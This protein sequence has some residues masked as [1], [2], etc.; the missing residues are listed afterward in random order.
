MKI[1]V[2]GA[3]GLLGL[4]FC[5]MDWEAHTVTGVDRGTLQNV[6]FNLINAELT[7]PEALS[8]LINDAK[9]EAIIHAA[10]N[11]NVDACEDDPFGTHYLN[12][13]I[14]GLMAEIAARESGE[15]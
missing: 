10:A 1:L 15:L 9:P 2:T 5:L 4:N 11:A 6:P 13:E 12:A 7:Q 3:S 8:R 14:P